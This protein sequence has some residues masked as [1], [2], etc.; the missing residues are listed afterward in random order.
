MRA[1]GFATMTTPQSTA[2][3]SSR[4]QATSDQVSSQ[5]TTNE[6]VRD[7]RT[8]PRKLTF[9][10]GV[11]ADEAPGPDIDC[12]VLN[13]SPHGARL[14]VPRGTAVPA[15]FALVM[16]PDAKTRYCRV[17]WQQ[18]CRVGVSYVDRQGDSETDR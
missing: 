16:E 10:T 8:A 4:R 2:A 3:R 14:L 7:N 15:E 17:M 18:D 5:V 9:R 6:F 1:R 12:A 13:E 11:I